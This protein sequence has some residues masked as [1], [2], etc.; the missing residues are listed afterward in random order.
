MPQ[1]VVHSPRRASSA[2]LSTA[3]VPGRIAPQWH[4]AAAAK[5]FEIKARVHDRYH[6]A[7]ECRSCGGVTVQRIF[8]LMSAQ[9]LC[10]ACLERRWQEDAEAAGVT[11]LG[12]DPDHRHYGR[13]RLA[14]GHETR[15]QVTLI[16]HVARGETGLRCSIC[17]RDHHAGMAQAA[18]WELVGP[19]PSGRTAYRLYRHGCGHEQEV[20]IG[21]MRTRRVG[22]GSCD[23]GWL[24][25]P[26][27][28]YAFRLSGPTGERWVKLGMSRDPDSRGRYQFGLSEGLDCE[29]LRAVPMPSGQLALRAEKALHRDLEARF[30][31]AVIPRAEL[32]PWI[33]VVTEVYAGH[34]EAEILRCL[35][36]LAAAT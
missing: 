16:Q 24:A 4:A 27:H 29:L 34:L 31:D 32:A 8:T 11:W 9:P 17:L 2:I 10:H 1:P 19:A 6:L 30:P 33:N 22:C 15:R 18:G 13:Y 21:N 3:P 20:A 14:C 25:A 12:R 5:G 7:L 26:S 36:E 23:P 35:D 28:I